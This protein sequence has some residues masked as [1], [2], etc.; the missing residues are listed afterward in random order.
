[1]RELKT[2]RELSDWLTQQ[3]YRRPGCGETKATVKYELQEPVA[4]GC[5]WSR[6]LSLTYGRTTASSCMSTCGR[7]SKRLAAASTSASLSP[8]FFLPEGSL[9]QEPS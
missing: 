9:L 2:R 6:D 1:M 3:L 7:S 8:T 5:N 4:D